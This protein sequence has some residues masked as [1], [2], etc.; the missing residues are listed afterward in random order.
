MSKIIEL[1]LLG[2][3]YVTS[4]QSVPGQ[5]DKS[6]LY[7]STGERAGSDGVAISQDLI[8]G[9]CRRLHRRCKH[10]EYP[11]RLHYGD[12][13]YVENVGY[14]RINDVM[15]RRFK[16]RMDVWVASWK[17]EHAFH[18]RFC[19]TNLTVYKLKEIQ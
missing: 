9:A 16:R 5:T 6:P 8:C 14:K 11:Y 10:P 7:T 4:Y 15:N 19:N 17:Q 12:W 18:L 13:L 2:S 3:F 1:I